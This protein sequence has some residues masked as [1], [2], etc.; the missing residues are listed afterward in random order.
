MQ[1]NGKDWSAIG[2]PK[3]STST[4]GNY[5][6]TP[7][8]GMDAQGNPAFV[9]LGKDGNPI[10]PKLP[11]GF[12]PAKDPI[13]IDTG[14]GTV[15][16]DP[17]TR[18]QV[19]FVPKDVAGEAAATAVGKGAGQAQLDL[20]AARQTA[21]MVQQQIRDLKADPYLPNM[22]G[23]VNS[24]LPNVSGSAARVQ[25]RMDQLQGGA[26]MQARQMLKGGGQITDFE[27]RK[28]EVAWLRMNAAQNVDDFKK[29]LDE[30]NDAVSQGV[31]KLEA[32]A[33]PSGGGQAAA[34]PAGAI[35]ALRANPALRDQFDAKYGQGA[36]ARAL[37]Q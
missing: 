4:E 24:R 30:F 15:I 6:T 36:A 26:F 1:W 5:G 34:P 25:S 7:I 14:V 8:W 29:A 21:A 37:G 11:P 16:L 10:Q 2:G 19:G 20:P 17:Q 28:A 33:R 18:Q 9:Q 23:P 31:A 32:Q 27:G 3:S 35:S 22:I 12:V 13:R